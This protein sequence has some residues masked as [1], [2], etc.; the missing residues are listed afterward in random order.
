MRARS[1]ENRRARVCVGREEG[2]NL[3]RARIRR[4]ER[5]FGAKARKYHAGLAACHACKQRKHGLCRINSRQ[6]YANVVALRAPH[7]AGHN[8][9]PGF[10][11]R[12]RKATRY[13]SFK[14]TL[15]RVDGS[16]ARP[17]MRGGFCVDPRFSLSPHLNRAEGRTSESPERHRRDW[18]F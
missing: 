15:P 2:E 10:R 5:R 16:R 17:H 8:P 3:A 11:R 13:V 12:G 14:W 1:W 7:E 6:S 9:N 4:V 18:W